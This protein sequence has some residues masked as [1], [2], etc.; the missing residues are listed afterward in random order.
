[1]CTGRC[2][3][4]KARMRR[5]L[6]KVTVVWSCE[7]YWEKMACV[8]SRFTASCTAPWHG[9]NFSNQRF[10]LF[11]FSCFFKFDLLNCMQ[12]WKQVFEP[13]WKTPLRV[14]LPELSPASTPVT[15]QYPTRALGR[16]FC[17]NQQIDL[18]ARPQASQDLRRVHLQGK[19]QET[20]TWHQERTN[21]RQDLPVSLTNDFRE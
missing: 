6:D 21:Q 15:P 18:F 2:Q 12:S 8:I 9:K 1:M 10:V 4:N 14:F 16:L 3:N 19:C 5:F 17:T 11:C 13:Y 20:V 7:Q